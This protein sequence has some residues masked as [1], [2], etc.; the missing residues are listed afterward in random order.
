MITGGGLLPTSI[1]NV[2]VS[3]TAFRIDSPPQ[4]VQIA[5]LT[6]RPIS[7]VMVP[8]VE[9]EHK[10]RVEFVDADGWVRGGM[11]VPVHVTRRPP[12]LLPDAVAWALTCT[13]VLVALSCVGAL[14]IAKAIEVFRV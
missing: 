8:Q 12:R 13:G 3:G 10:V 9:G 6:L 11:T 5:A 1:V 7:F 2:R 4:Q 14:L